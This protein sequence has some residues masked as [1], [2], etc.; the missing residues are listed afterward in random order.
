[1][2]T[3]TVAGGTI[4]SN[5]PSAYLA[6]KPGESPGNL[7]CRSIFKKLKYEMFLFYVTLFRQLHDTIC[8]SFIH[9]FEPFSLNLC[10]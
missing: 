3:Y 8:V 7:A 2:Q 10:K 9:C 4:T 6:N 5:S 1:M